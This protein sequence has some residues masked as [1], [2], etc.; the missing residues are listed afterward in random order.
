ML[1]LGLSDSEIA[2]ALGLHLHAVQSRFRR[3]HERTGLVGR[4]AVAWA[5][6]HSGCCISELAA[7]SAS[8]R[9]IK[10]KW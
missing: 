2:G 1:A 3:V 4:L 8:M 10:S 9:I 7:R 5:A 6:H